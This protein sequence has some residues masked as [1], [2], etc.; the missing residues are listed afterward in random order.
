MKTDTDFTHGGFTGSDTNGV[1]SPVIDGQYLMP[2]KVVE[3]FSGS[4]LESVNDCAF[5]ST[6]A[7]VRE[8]S[9]NAMLRPAPNI[10]RCIPVQV[11]EL[12]PLPAWKRR[13]LAA[14]EKYAA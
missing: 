11:R 9:E 6:L 2:R 7:A 10:L 8:L 1:A 13:Q 5:A 4:L 12:K 14:A 3:K